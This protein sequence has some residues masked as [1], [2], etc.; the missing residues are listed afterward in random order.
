MVKGLQAKWGTCARTVSLDDEPWALACWKDLVVVGFKSGNIMIL[1]VITGICTSSL[2]S[3]TKRVNSLAFSLDGI[4]LV[5]GSDDQT[6]I[7][8][9]IQTGGVIRT[10]HGHTNNVWSVSISPDYTKIASGSS[11]DTIRLWDTQSGECHCII[12]KH[13]SSVWSVSFSPINSQLLVSASKDG[14][15]RQWNIDGHQIG[16]HYKGNCVVFS[17]DGTNFVSWKWEGRVVTVWD[18]NSGGVVANIQKPNGNLRCCCFSLNGKFVAGGIDDTIYIW[19]ITGL[20]PCL[21]ETLTGH[22][23]FITS[24][25][26]S[27]SLISS[28]VD[29]SVKFWQTGNSPTDSV[30]TDSESTQLTSAGIMSVSLQV[31]NG[32]AISSDSAGVVKTWDILTGLCKASFQTPAK[33]Y[34]HGGTQLIEDR[35]IFVWLEDESDW[36]DKHWK[37]YAWDSKKGESLQILDIQ[38]HSYPMDLRISADGSRVFLLDWT[39]IQVWS[40]WTG[41]VMGEVA[42]EGN[43]LDNSLIVDRSRVWVCLRDLQTRGWDF[44]VPGSTPVPLPHSLLD[45]PH[46]MFFGNKWECSIPSRVENIIT[47]KK[48]FQLL[49]RYAKPSVARLDGQY[50]VTGYNSGD[51]LILDFNHMISQ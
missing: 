7:L 10:F 26:F 46:L 18:S 4:F 44:G 51:V 11:D 14:T 12:N 31:T 5:S 39:Y 21:F 38:T 24:L 45:R 2:S 30:I 19:D 6:V 9:D 27:S 34:I 42:L 16:P 40:I 22:N 8:W 41:Q 37:I 47:R 43:P 3:H 33:D 48:V 36:E 13:N 25:V 32:I 15:I 1:D 49:G 23:S 50:L 28:S 29:G 20:T 35:L 17:L